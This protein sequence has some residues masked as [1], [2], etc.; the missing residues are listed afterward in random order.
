MNNAERLIRLEEEAAF[1]EQKLEA[2]STALA[3][4]QKQLDKMEADLLRLAGR[5]QSA[6]AALEE[7]SGGPVSEKPPH[8]L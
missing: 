3:A 1:Q 4:Q 7:T 2:L 6:L 5:L 8:Y